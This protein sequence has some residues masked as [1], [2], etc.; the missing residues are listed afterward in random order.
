VAAAEA[1]GEAAVLPRVVEVVVDAWAVAAVTN[2]FAVVVDVR[3]FGVALDV[4]SRPGRR[5]MRGR[6]TTLG[7]VPAADC[8]TASAV[9]AMLR[10]YGQGKDEEH[11]KKFGD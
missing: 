9:A 8:M 1:A 5:A 10:E 11:Q 3:S 6:W 4:F 7:D 2:P